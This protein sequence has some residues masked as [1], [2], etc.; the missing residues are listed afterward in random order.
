MGGVLNAKRATL[1]I[2]LA[3]LIVVGMA[4]VCAMLV[5]SFGDIGN[6]TGT[7]GDPRIWGLFGS[8]LY[9]AALTTAIAGVAGIA[10]GILVAKTDL[11]F[12]RALT[13]VFSFPLLFPP[14]I[15][16]VGSYE[17][18]GRGGLLTQWAGPSLGAA[19]SNWL[20]DL[21]G[22]VLVLSIAFMPVVLLLTVLSLAAVNPSLEQAAR[23]SGDWLRVLR[24]ISLPLASPGVVLALVLVF[25]LS[26]GEFGAPAFLRVSVFPVASFTELTAFYNFGR[27]TAAAVPS[28]AVALV[29]L[30]VEKRMLRGRSFEY[31]RKAGSNV[32][33]I[34]L[35]Y[36]KAPIAFLVTLISL[37]LVATP[38]AALA[39]RGLSLKAMSE[40][41]ERAGD[42]AFRSVAY[43]GAAAT[44]LTALGFLLAYLI[45]RHSDSI[46]GWV[47]SSVFLLFTV[48]GTVTGIGL[49][50]LWNR[51]STN[52][53]Y[54]TP[55]ILVAGYVGQYL[56]LGTRTIL[57]GFTQTSP[58]LEEAAEISGAGWFR[59]VFGILAPIV[60]P[61]L[62][63]SWAVTFI[64]C[65]RDVT[66]PLLL[67]PP[68]RDT[69]T[70]RTMTLMA[71]GS[72]QLVAA[73]CLLT[74]SLTLVPLI[75][76]GAARRVWSRPV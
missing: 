17:V 56:A 61:A 74:I 38:L 33:R 51:P 52:W 43:S 28:L 64:F 72:A 25:L 36:G 49:I 21:P 14:Y 1:A 7:L 31:G 37:I 65:L 20:F 26:F 19:A 75:V 4:P 76:C 47:D 5:A 73:L 22:A 35:G 58:R 6:Y 3:V 42:S 44:V 57:A 66:L 46:G 18:L 9:L 40:A 70:S 69:L 13:V 11:P 41:I 23:L 68:G 71:N 63:M 29:G 24:D 27:A 32:C 45:H 30:A 67:A 59:R 48:P 60:A 34:E 53:I 62:M 50:A 16:A 39:W 8:S 10:L 15:L 55:A 54:A 12:R 2:A